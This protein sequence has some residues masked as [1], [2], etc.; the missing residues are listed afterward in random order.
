MLIV[1]SLDI[2]IPSSII[3]LS[4]GFLLVTSLVNSSALYAY[5]KQSRSKILPSLEEITKA[6][7]IDIKQLDQI[8]PNNEEYQKALSHYFYG[9]TEEEV[10]IVSALI[11]ENNLTFFFFS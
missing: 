11:F 6:G 8:D 7:P 3:N 4:R 9:E 5:S 10:A 1:N 2:P